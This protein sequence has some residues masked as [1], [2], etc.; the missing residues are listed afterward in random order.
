MPVEKFAN[1]SIMTIK[2]RDASRLQIY[3]NPMK[4]ALEISEAA[5]PLSSAHGRLK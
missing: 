3:L 1:E 5:V 2:M 4:M